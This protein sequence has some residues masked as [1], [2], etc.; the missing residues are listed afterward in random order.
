MPVGAAL[1]DGMITSQAMKT[2]TRIVKQMN[3]S[4]WGI[5]F[6]AVVLPIVD[7]AGEIVGA[8]SVYKPALLIY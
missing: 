5:P 8:I 4:H 2:R 7:D 6:V 1:H 3:A